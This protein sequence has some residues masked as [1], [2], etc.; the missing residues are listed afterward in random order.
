M[1]GARVALSSVPAKGITVDGVVAVLLKD[2]VLT[3]QKVAANQTVLKGQ[4]VV[5]G[6]EAMSVQCSVLNETGVF[7]GIADSNGTRDLTTYTTEIPW[8]S[9]CRG[10]IGRGIP[11]A[12]LSAAVYAKASADGKFIAAATIADAHA[13]VRAVGVMG[14]TLEGGGSYPTG[15]PFGTVSAVDLEFWT[16]GK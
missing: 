6:S 9:V 8:V 11:A 3:R 10:P 1:S 13:R 12:D 7:A 5:F 16:F 4:A 2:S 15:L 14:D